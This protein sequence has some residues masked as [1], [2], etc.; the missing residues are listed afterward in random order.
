ML[1]W[2]DG[3]GDIQ[4]GTASI[5]YIKAIPRSDS[6]ASVILPLWTND[7]KAVAIEEKFPPAHS[8]VALEQ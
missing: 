4:T 3:K 2:I 7:T 1:R 6:M 5:T 8:T